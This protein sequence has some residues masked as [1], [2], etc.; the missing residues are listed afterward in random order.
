MKLRLLAAV[1]VVVLLVGCGGAPPDKADTDKGEAQPYTVKNFVSRTTS[2][3]LKQKTAHMT[4]AIGSGL[5]GVTCKGVVLNGSSVK[6]SG[7]RAEYKAP[8]PD[9]EM[10]AVKGIIYV[11]YGDL[12]QDKFV[13]IDPGDSTN[14]LS[15]QFAPLMQSMDPASTI[16]QFAGAITRVKRSGKPK[17][18]D[19]I[20]TTPYAITIDT[21][22]IKGPLFDA[23]PK[24]AIPEKLKYV[25]YMAED[26]I[27]RR[28]VYD[29]GPLGDVI[30]NFTRIGE[31]VDIV[32]PGKSDQIDQ[33]IL[34]GAGQTA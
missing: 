22:K 26:N 25:Y 19:R 24:G 1:A 13:A 9:F 11:N 6:T 27:P 14:E 21:D 34:K 31:P 23:M 4:L 28:I 8:G 30:V 12:T 16:R 5:N 18:L 10:R 2:A 7:F 29:A 32:A 20:D 15:R 33:S 3:W 17:K